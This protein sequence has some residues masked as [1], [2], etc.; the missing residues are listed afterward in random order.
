MERQRR[1]WLFYM[2]NL[3]PKQFIMLLTVT[4]MTAMAGIPAFAKSV[5]Q[6]GDG[7]LTMLPIMGGLLGISVIAVIIVV[8]LKKR[9]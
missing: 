2:R 4:V 9:K 3:W 1:E 7:A 8:V 6:T 5:P